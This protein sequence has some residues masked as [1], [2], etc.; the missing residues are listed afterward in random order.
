MRRWALSALIACTLACEPQAKL[1]DTPLGAKV[2]TKSEGVG[3]HDHGQLD[4]ILREHVRYEAGRVDYQGLAKA[5]PQLDAYLEGLAQADLAALTADERKALLIN[6]YNAFTLALVLDNYPEIGSIRDLA[7]PWGRRVWRLGGELVS[8]DDI[9]HGLLR[10]VYKDPRVHFAVNCASIGCPPLAARAYDGA[11]LAARLDDAT[12]QALA[13]PAYAVQMGGTLRLTRIMDW[14][15]G[16][17]VAPDAAP[18]A[19]SVAAFVARYA[20]TSE[21][22]ETI[23]FMDYDWRLND[24]EP[25]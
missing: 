24:V 19:D 11:N 16:D 21:S 7:D 20:K 6:A 5:R 25:H 17:F 2:A 3:A 12:T 14:Y 13:R 15:G 22:P 1:L 4:R 23:E 18:R 10:P 9:E 8:L